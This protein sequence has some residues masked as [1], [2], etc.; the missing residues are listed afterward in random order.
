MAVHDV[1]GVDGEHPVGTQFPG[2]DRRPAERDAIGFGIDVETVLDPE[3]RN[4]EA[5]ILAHLFAQAGEPRDQRG[6]MLFVREMDQAI[7]ELDR[8][9]R[10]VGHFVDRDLR[11]IGCGDRLDIGFLDRFAVLQ[12]APE[13][14]GPA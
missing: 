3:G 12:A 8:H 1:A 14:E 10:L 2:A 7:A 5:E 9:Q 11:R 4:D 13:Q 6:A